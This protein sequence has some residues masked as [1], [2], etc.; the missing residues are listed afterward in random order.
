MFTDTHLHILLFIGVA[1]FATEMSS[2]S[3]VPKQAYKMSFSRI[4]KLN[5][6]GES[7]FHKI[8]SYLIPIDI[9]IKRRR[10][11]HLVSSLILTDRYWYKIIKSLYYCRLHLFEV[12]SNGYDNLDFEKLIEHCTG[13]EFTR[14]VNFS[15]AQTFDDD[16]CLQLIQAAP[17]IESLY[18]RLL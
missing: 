1:W 17:F 16:M 6:H 13:K 3:V 9:N 5:S 15:K 14:D 18:R 4:A 10:E 12:I 2:S 8:V 7:L 11:R